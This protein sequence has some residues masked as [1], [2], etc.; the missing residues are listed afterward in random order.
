MKT[1][2]CSKCQGA[3]PTRGTF[4]GLCPT[5]LLRGDDDSISLDGE[6]EQVVRMPA[7]SSLRVG[8]RV[9]NYRVEAAIG[10]GG[11]SEVYRVADRAGEQYALKLAKLL[12]SRPTWQLELHQ[13]ELDVLKRLAHPSLVRGRD[14]GALPDGRVYIVMDLVEGTNLRELLRERGAL[15]PIE[16]VWIATQI[17]EGLAYCHELGILHLDLK[18]QNIMVVDRDSLRVRVLDFGLTR[19]VSSWVAD[20]PLVTAGTPGYAAPEYFYGGSARTLDSRADLYSLGVVL[21]ELLTG[22][23]PVQGDSTAE[24]LRAQADGATLRL[25]ARL[26]KQLGSLTP[27]LYS[28]LEREP[29]ARYPSAAMLA[30]EL[31]LTF[32]QL[33]G[34][35]SSSTRTVDSLHGDWLSARTPMVGREAEFTKLQQHFARVEAGA[36]SGIEILGQDGLGKSRLVSELVDCVRS[37]AFTAHARCPPN[38]SFVRMT[39][40]KLVLGRLAKSLE[41]ASSAVRE[42]VQENLRN[43]STQVSRALGTIAPELRRLLTVDLDDWEPASATVRSATPKQIA[44]GLESALCAISEELPILLVIEDVEWADF[45]TLEI[46]KRMRSMKGRILLVFTRG[47]AVGVAGLAEQILRLEP[48]TPQA[49]VELITSLSGCSPAVAKLLLRMVPA[50][51]AGIPSVTRDVVRD[52]SRRG[53]LGGPHPQDI[54]LEAALAHYRTPATA[55]AFLCKTM[56]DFDPH[57]RRI[58]GLAASMGLETKLSELRA[59]QLASSEEVRE[60]LSRAQRAGIATVQQGRFRFTDESLRIAAEAQLEA[61]SRTHA[62]ERMEQVMSSP[63]RTRVQHQAASMACEQALAAAKASL[64]AARRVEAREPRQALPD[65]ERAFALLLPQPRQPELDALLLELIR[66][67]ARIGGSL[68][69]TDAVLARLAELRVRFGDDAA[70]SLHAAESALRCARGEL[71]GGLRCGREAL[72]YARQQGESAVIEHI[73]ATHVLGCAF[74]AS[75]QIAA[76]VQTLTK[77]FE[78]AEKA[79]ITQGADHVC[80]LLAAGLGF[81]GR[82]DDASGYLARGKREAARSGHRV[83]VLDML[84]CE[85]LLAEAKCDHAGGIAAAVPLIRDAARYGLR[86]SYPFFGH[87]LAGR[88]SYWAGELGKAWFL[89]HRALDLAQGYTARIAVGRVHAYIGDV[90]LVEGRVSEAVDAYLRGEQLAKARG[91]RDGNALAHCAMGLAHCFAQ[92]GRERER[93]DELVRRAL[94]LTRRAGHVIGHIHALERGA[95][96]QRTLGNSKAAAKFDQLWEERAS[97]LGQRR[98]RWRPEVLVRSGDELTERAPERARAQQHA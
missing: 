4:A 89:L 97:S 93:I 43:K 53:Y 81:A 75:G 52:L 98:V 88:H 28:L 48:L 18:P 38:A 62:R 83:H 86:G 15:E 29:E 79:G 9:G 96:I 34:G 12:D 24:V 11:L 30:R 73:E 2:I 46:L 68:G 67:F 95:E 47:T 72:R 80:G 45:D 74:F 40:L 70:A 42:R 22:S 57:V 36:A 37:R 13:N 78:L 90:L 87:V 27:L 1:Q 94:S 50:L 17:S 14:G 77:S 49:N 63:R 41:Q 71:A 55:V 10:T 84:L 5:C 7:G 3:L 16:A 23:L 82:F 64:A 66:E 51:Q 32:C 39:P 31:T 21:F 44:S 58:L 59:L 61:E 69:D 33:V 65:L 54:R 35:S 85:S 76:A 26:E 25:P 56:Q 20:A 19:A 92:L 60:A 91:A 8:Q 6:L